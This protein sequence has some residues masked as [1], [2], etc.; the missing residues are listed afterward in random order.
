LRKKLVRSIRREG[1]HFRL[2]LADGS[3]Y[4]SKVVLA[5]LGKRSSLDRDLK[6]EPLQRSPWTAWKMHFHQAEFPAHEVHLHNFPGGYAGLSRV[7]EGRINMAS[8]LH[9]SYL[10]PG[11][12]AWPQVKN[13]LAQNPHL[14]AFFASAEALLSQPVAISQLDYGTRPQVAQG[15]LLLGDTAGMIHP[16]SGNGM[17]MAMGS[18]Q[19]AAAAVEPFLSGLGSRLQMEAQ[20]RHSWQAQYRRRLQVSRLLRRFFAASQRSEWALR[21]ALGLPPLT[22]WLE[23]QTHG[24][25]PAL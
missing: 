18:A 12:P 16:L 23:R 20:Y 3:T 15:V 6:I 14:R 2:Q 8:L 19:L 13:A 17:A 21:L 4:R 11:R 22:R 7:E 24:K 1:E 10:R 5:A 25:A 9:Q